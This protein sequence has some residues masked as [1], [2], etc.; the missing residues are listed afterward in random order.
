MSSAGLRT[1]LMT[2]K[3]MQAQQTKF[4]LCSLQT[5]IKEIMQIAGFD[6]IISVVED[7]A[8]AKEQVS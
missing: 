1:I 7:V 5:N 2:A 6:R 8:A 4:S 3:R